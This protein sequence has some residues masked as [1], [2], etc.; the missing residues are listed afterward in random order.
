M[1]GDIKLTDDGKTDDI[2]NIQELSE[3]KKAQIKMT[4]CVLGGIAVLFLCSA[5]AY[6]LTE[7]GTS[8]YVDDVRKICSIGTP[9]H[10]HVVEFCHKYMTLAKSEANAAAKE[11]FEFCKNFLPPIVTLVL[12]AHYVTKSNQND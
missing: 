12:G 7:N 9:S 3:A 8:A 1:S 5:G 2:G 4:Y 10:D 11:V 6:I